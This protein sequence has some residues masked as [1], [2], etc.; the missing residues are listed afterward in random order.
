MMYV[1]LLMHRAS[2]FLVCDPFLQSLVFFH[3]LSFALPP[4]PPTPPPTHT[5]QKLLVE[6]TWTKEETD[7]LMELCMTFDLRF[8][9][10]QDRFDTTKFQVHVCRRVVFDKPSTLSLSLCIL[11][12]STYSLSLHTCVTFLVSMVIEALS[13]SS[14]GALLQCLQSFVS[15]QR[16]KH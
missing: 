11:S 10:I 9:I 2:R 4:S 1:Q 3:T 14:E 13:G 7:H 16:P 8:I 5:L 12:F 6:P 15:S